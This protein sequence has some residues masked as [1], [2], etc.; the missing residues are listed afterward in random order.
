MSVNG[1]NRRSHPVQ[2][3]RSESTGC[4]SN[5]NPSRPDHPHH[6]GR[7]GRSQQDAQAAPTTQHRWWSGSGRA[8]MLVIGKGV[9]LM[10]RARATTRCTGLTIQIV[11]RESHVSSSFDSWR[12]S[13]PWSFFQGG[14][15]IVPPDFSSKRK[16]VEENHRCYFKKLFS[17]L[18]LA[19]PSSSENGKE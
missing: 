19:F 4:A 18:N 12:L 8:R 3:P 1:L 17:W 10:M 5:T 13:W 7:S 6:S 2:E 15:L 14:I 16:Q 11:R 9:E